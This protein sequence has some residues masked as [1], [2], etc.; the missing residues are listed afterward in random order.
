M[1]L[2]SDVR[3][4]YTTNVDKRAQKGPL[5]R[6]CFLLPLPTF[7]FRLRTSDF[8]R[9]LPAATGAASRNTRSQ[10]RT[11]TQQGAVRRCVGSLLTVLGRG[12]LSSD[13]DGS[14]AAAATFSSPRGRRGHPNNDSAVAAW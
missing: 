12:P 4:G 11:G 13:T 14:A 6:H 10:H 1:S 9:R 3:R 7:D 8:R 5:S 2:S